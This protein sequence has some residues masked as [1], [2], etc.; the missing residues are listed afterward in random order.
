GN[1]EK[2]STARH[3]LGFYNGVALAATYSSPTPSIALQPLVYSALRTVIARH[4]IL[5]AI[6]VNEDK[7]DTYFARLPSINLRSCVTFILREKPWSLDPTHASPDPELDSLIQAQLAQDFKSDYGSKPFWRVVVLHTS[8]GPDSNSSDVVIDRFTLLW[9]FHHALADGTSGHILHSAFLSALNS[10][11]TDSISSDPDITSP[12]TPLHPPLESLHPLPISIFFL[13]KTVFS[14]WFPRNVSRIWSGALISPALNKTAVRTLVFDRPMSQELVLRSREH[15][16]TLTGT[17]H[18]VVAAVLLSVLDAGRWDEVVSQG[19]ISLR[20]FIALP[21]SP[22][23]PSHEVENYMD[24][25]LGTFAT[26][27]TF[28]HRRPTTTPARGPLALFSWPDAQRVRSTISSELTKRGRNSGIGLLRY[29][30]DSVAFFDQKVGASREE[31]F[32]VSNIGMFKPST[33]PTSSS[34]GNEGQGWSIGRMTFLQHGAVAGAAFKVN[35]VTGG[36]GCLCLGVCWV[37]GGIEE[38]VIEKVV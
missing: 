15:G 25:V 7:N 8:P 13:L 38:E 35:A 3:Y 29:V 37:E 30:S 1:L 28:P 17:L 18:S 26:S 19:T 9:T 21:A 34:S 10:L 4:S 20:R 27:Y 14:S 6:P 31:A 33:K 36:D 11:T 23:S 12:S 2:F 5:S 32:E 24:N 22:S 16:T